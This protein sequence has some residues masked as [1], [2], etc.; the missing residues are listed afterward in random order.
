MYN[1]KKDQPVV[2][3]VFYLSLHIAV[4]AFSVRAVGQ[5][6][7]YAKAVRTLFTGKELC[8]RYRDPMSPS[9]SAHTHNFLS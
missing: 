2:V 3:H 6:A 9:L 5:P 1:Q 7:H 4:N 8:N